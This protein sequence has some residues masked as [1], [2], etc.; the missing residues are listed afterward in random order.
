VA[1]L[2]TQPGIVNEGERLEKLG[3]TWCKIGSIALIALF[4]KWALL[5]AGTLAIYYYA[6]ALLLGVTRSCCVLRHPLLIIA[7]WLAAMAVDMVF[8]AWPYVSRL[9]AR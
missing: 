9:S 8:I 2:G 4:P 6:R 7:F 3:F 5:L 1:E